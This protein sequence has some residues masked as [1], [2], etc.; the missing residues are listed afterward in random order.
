M[1]KNEKKNANGS[2][3]EE[4]GKKNHGVIKKKIMNKLELSQ[5]ILVQ[6]IYITKQKKKKR[7]N[8]DDSGFE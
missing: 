6:K 1:S 7:G 3:G 8:K 2:K 5:T 4:L